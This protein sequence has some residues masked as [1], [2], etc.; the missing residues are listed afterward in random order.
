MQ[1]MNVLPTEITRRRVEG[2]YHQHVM[3]QRSHGA[4]AQNGYP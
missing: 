2:Q 3:N 4:G 1:A